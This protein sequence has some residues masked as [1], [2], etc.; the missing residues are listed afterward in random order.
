[1]TLSSSLLR[2]ALEAA[3]QVARDGESA[4]PATPAPPML[5]RY[6]SFARLPGPALDVARRV[7]DDDPEFR[8]RVAER[9]SAEEV[10][11]AAWV[12]LSRPDGWEARLEALTRQAQDADRAARDD[13]AE[14][15]AQRRLAGAEAAARR[16][17]L[18]LRGRTRERDEAL[19]ALGGER[20]RREQLEQAL[21]VA[22]QEAAT[23]LEERNTAVR[24]LKRVEADQA[25]RAG[26]LRT[27]R[28][29]IRMLE[30]ELSQG[31]EA[32]GPAAGPSGSAPAPVSVL[33]PAERDVLAGAVSDAADANRRLRDALR[34]ASAVLAPA[35]PD[36]HAPAVPAAAPRAGDGRAP[37]SRRRTRRSPSPLPPGT[38]DDAPA[39][40]DYLCRMAG[41]VVLVDGYNV[42]QRAWPDHSTDEQRARL[43][44]ALRELHAR[45]GADVEVVFDGAHPDPVPVARGGGRDPVRVRFS[46]PGVEADDVVLERA[47]DVAAARPVVV[48]SS[49]RYVR[50]GARRI[51]ANVVGAAQ[52]LGALRR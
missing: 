40:A 30:A 47:A 26:E 19:A 45:T 11:E 22:A 8:R 6:L 28:H 38:L 13:K 5:R 37:S 9:T 21:A 25:A 18:V 42:S 51:G 35:R 4:A 20:A 39:A 46:P 49:D 7:V 2:P 15:S 44:D 34:R 14:R 23:R 27:A 50:D 36:G 48:A 32:A 29:Q 16:A 33:G 3:V 10:G 43:V 31:A 12:W 24:A 41:V 17:E 1:M 52:L